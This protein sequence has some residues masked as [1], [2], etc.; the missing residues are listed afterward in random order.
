MPDLLKMNL[1]KLTSIYNT[2]AS[3][4][5]YYTPRIIKQISLYNDELLYKKQV[6]SN[7]LLDKNTLFVLNQLLTSPFDYNLID[8]AKPTLLN[9][10]PNTIFAA[11]TG[12]NET[13]SYT[14]GY[15]PKYTIS[16]WTGTDDNENFY[17]HNV[18]KKVFFE[19]VNSI[20]KQNIWYIPNKNIKQI[21]IDPISGKY[22]PNGSI[23]WI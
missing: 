14:I 11:K 18:S 4:G 16:V 9:Y 13:N 20:N 17:S 3:L 15:N 1:L 19:L 2:F 6:S 21:L 23:Y 22:D 8:Y 7:H 10:K 5:T 12:S